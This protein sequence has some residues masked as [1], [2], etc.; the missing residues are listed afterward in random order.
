MHSITANIFDS[1]PSEEKGKAHRWVLRLVT[2]TQTC[3]GQE[4]SSSAS[5]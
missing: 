4:S 2:R 5:A 3:T 1:Q